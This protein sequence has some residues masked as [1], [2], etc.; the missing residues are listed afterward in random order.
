MKVIINHMYVI[1]FNKT[2]TSPM[3]H[4][5]AGMMKLRNYAVKFVYQNVSITA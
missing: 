1:P 4:T 5:P 2:I 3:A